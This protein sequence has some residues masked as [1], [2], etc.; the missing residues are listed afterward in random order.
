MMPWLKLSSKVFPIFV[1][2]GKSVRFVRLSLSSTRDEPKYRG[3]DQYE[4]IA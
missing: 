3:R 4:P 2:L 1:T